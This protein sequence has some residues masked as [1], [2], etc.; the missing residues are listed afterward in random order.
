MRVILTFILA[1][2]CLLSQGQNFT[3]KGKEFWVGYGHCDLFYVGNIQDMVVYL[4]AE[5]PANVTMSIPGTG[6]VKTYSIAANSVVV[7]DI[8]P[9]SGANDA[10]ITDEGFSQK[11]VHIVSDVPIVAYAHLYGQ[12][13][14]GAAMLLPVETYGYTYFSINAAQKSDANS[15]S[16]FYIVAAED[17]TRIRIT[18]SASTLKKRPAGV[19]F[20]VAL[21]KGEI[22]NVMG[23]NFGRDEGNDMSG[24]TV[25]SVPGADGK[26]H[27]ITMFSGNSRTRICSPLDASGDWLMQQVFP[28][29]AW[30][31]RYMAVPTVVEGDPDKHNLNRFRVYITDP[32]DLSLRVDTNGVKLTGLHVEGG[33]YEFDTKNPL[34]ITA[35]KPIMVAQLIPSQEGCGSVGLGDPEIFFLS[36][37]EQAIKNVAFYST[38]KENI[39][40]NYVSLTIPENGMSSLLIDGSPPS[41]SPYDHP[42]LPGYK[43][44][45]QELAN[46][47]G[48]HTITSDSGFNAITYGLGKYESYG[49]NAGCYINNLTYLAELKNDLS[50]T[51]NTYTCPNTPFSINIKTLY[52]LTGIA[53]H[54]G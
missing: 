3:N 28:L 44:L 8:L 2:T 47:P 27:P 32:G 52:P 30:G 50:A 16:W 14:S 51:P 39:L 1:F 22:Y 9:K 33:Y 25:I 38:N 24:S 11:A 45:V 12:F 36:P 49:Y 18:P 15:F 40:S 4:S 53:W 43:I 6:W 10:R 46:T 20:D 17:N 23:D 48:Q 19:S 21:K 29:T 37:I 54:Y 41:G 35:N 26:C 13:R 42:G 34:Y 5:Q 7:S 31:A